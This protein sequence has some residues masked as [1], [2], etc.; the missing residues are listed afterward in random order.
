M[1]SLP[2]QLRDKRRTLRTEQR[3]L[4]KMIKD[5]LSQCTE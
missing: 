5:G 4:D 2:L 3:E 1:R